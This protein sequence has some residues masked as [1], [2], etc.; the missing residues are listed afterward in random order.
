MET[1]GGSTSSSSL[2]YYSAFVA[3]FSAGGLAGAVALTFLTRHH[4][5]KNGLVFAISIAETVM[6]YSA[7]KSSK[8]VSLKQT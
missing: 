7:L 6:L 2:V 8:T 3:V 4:S 1:Q 5:K